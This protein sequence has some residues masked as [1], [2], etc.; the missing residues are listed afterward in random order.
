MNPVL[1]CHLY[2][3]IVVKLCIG[4]YSKFVF[5]T[6]YRDIKYVEWYSDPFG[7]RQD[8]FVSYII[9]LP[10]VDKYKSPF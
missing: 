9:Y 3:A 6:T 2:Y 5:A 1:F 7:W 10:A 4:K 8:S